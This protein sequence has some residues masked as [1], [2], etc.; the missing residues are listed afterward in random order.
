MKHL[1]FLVT[2][3]PAEMR[4][5][6]EQNNP[7]IALHE[8]W[9]RYRSWR[10][11]L[12]LIV[13][14]LAIA[15]GGIIIQVFALKVD[16]EYVITLAIFTC[17]PVAMLFYIGIEDPQDVY[18]SRLGACRKSAERLGINLVYLLEQGSNLESIQ[19]LEFLKL[20]ELAVAVL[21]AHAVLDSVRASGTKQ[22]LKIAIAADDGTEEQLNLTL[23]AATEF[24]LSDGNRSPLSDAAK[25]LLGWRET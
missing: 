11:V 12:F 19:T 22:D 9:K 15:M 25:K 3:L 13:A 16:G 14:G 24:G 21:N 4:N 6:W 5:A 1:K 17:I 10:R 23:R 2:T 18:P 20:V 7:G 8:A